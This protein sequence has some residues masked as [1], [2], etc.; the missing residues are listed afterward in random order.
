MRLTKVFGLAALA[1]VAAMAFIGTSTA[2]AV[3]EVV[4]CKKLIE[5]G[6]L[7]PAGELWPAGTK[8]TALAEN[9]ELKGSGFFVEPTKCE[10]SILT[11]LS[12]AAIG[13]PLK[14]DN[15]VVS[16]GVLPSP[17][18]GA[19]CTG[20]CTNGAQENIHALFEELRIGVEGVDEFFI[21]G[22][23]LAGLL[24]C[25]FGVKCAYRAE[26][27]KVPI[28]HT[29]THRAHAG[30]NLPLAKIEVVLNRVTSHHGVAYNGFPCPTTATWNATYVLILAEAG[31]VKGLAW[32]ALD[33]K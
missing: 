2:S 21:L 24:N 9:P 26:H 23:G 7:C 17:T 10:D 29:G 12:E 28:T 16:F 22:K 32:P 18:L 3:D 6:K 8:L 33:I 4:L 19:N 15:A 13:N 5:K 14:F 25:D 1:A 20:G 11:G 27:V 30:T 31:E